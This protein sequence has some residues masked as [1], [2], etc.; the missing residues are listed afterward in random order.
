MR[1]LKRDSKDS[2]S[3]F[4][5]N[6][7][8][9]III[10]CVA[11]IAALIIMSVTSI[12]IMKNAAV[13]KLK[14]FDLEVLAESISTKIESKI[15][16]AVDATLIM[17]NDPMVARWVESGDKEES[18]E[19]QVKYR[20]DEFVSELGYDTT[21]L[22]SN[23]THNYWDC[24]EDGFQLL[25]TVSEDDTNDDWFFQFIK[26]KKKYE[27]NID[28]NSELNDTF[29][30]INTLVGDIKDPVAVTG[31]GMNLSQVI[32]E[33][34]QEDKN[35]SVQNEIWLVDESGIIYLAKNSMYLEKNI[36]EY[37]PD[38]LINKMDQQENL[39][40]KFEISEYENFEGNLYDIAYKNIKNT[41]WK[42][43]VQI[44][45]AD[46]VRFLKSV[47]VSTVISCSIIIMLMVL[48]FYLLSNQI[49]NPYKRSLQLNQ[50]LEKI[51][52]E[53]TK[54]LQEKNLKIQDSL[55]YAEMIQ[56]T[57]LP[58]ADEMKQS[59]R[60]Y[61]A[62]Y[63]PRDTVGGDFY[64]LRTYQEGSLLV[65]GDCTGHG[66]P[67]A[68]M[69][70]AVNAML[71]HIVDEMCR[72]DPARVLKELDRLMKQA[73]RK[74]S[75][76]EMI[77]DGLD[78]AVF[79][80]TK[81]KKIIYSGANIPV[82]ICDGKDVVEIRGS[83]DTIECNNSKKEKRFENFDINFDENNII[84]VATDGF[85]DQLGGAKRLP[86][87]KKRLKALLKEVSGFEMREQKDIIIN[88]L[89]NYKAEESRCDDITMLG[90]KL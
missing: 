11:I 22:V 76:E 88:T 43:I 53:R 40:D 59:V 78:A 5:N 44:P 38:T 60:D 84:Y 71:D 66:V 63:E 89:M 8:K 13:N 34:I 54:E 81:S 65:I 37:L 25:D 82:Y 32:S 87:G 17:A 35:S 72:D 31:L 39:E 10:G 61:F 24:N 30:W 20:M 75:G 73:F 15:D 19:E 48:T 41:E 6:S 67:G 46:S 90:F 33:L 23:I 68:L 79:Y 47:T 50:E 55:D 56:H 80:I 1:I 7:K 42:I 18:S 3:L 85:K 74:V 57:I 52:S 36:Q 69:T 86:F 27:I 14:T 21:F 64:W 4:D 58:L 77:T 12:M 51:V 62:V 9:V 29:V 28:Y 2:N 49:A 16:K 45:R 83:H 26:S 70:T